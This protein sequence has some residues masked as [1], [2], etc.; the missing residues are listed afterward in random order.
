[1]KFSATGKFRIIFI[2]TV[3]ILAAGLT[4]FGIFGYN[5]AADYKDGYQLNVSV[6]ENFGEA[7]DV[8][9]TATDEYLSA[10]GVKSA[11]YGFQ[12]IDDGEALVYKFATDIGDKIDTAELEASVK[13]ALTDESSVLSGLEVTCEYDSTINYFDS[14][15]I[16]LII[17]GCIS[18]VAIFVYI[19]IMERLAGAVTVAAVTLLSALIFFAALGLTRIPAYP[20]VG[21][22]IVLCAVLSAVFAAGLVSR[23]KEQL[24]NAAGTKVSG[25][26]IADKGTSF[27]MFRIIFIF[28]AL[29]FVSVLFTA[30][31][32]TYIRFMG[33]QLLLADIVA[34]FTAVGYAPFLWSSIKKGSDVKKT[35]KEKP[36]EE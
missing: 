33:L 5:Q 13:Q 25:R 6:S 20:F 7:A 32:P 34:T 11:G 14:Q 16:G 27:G 24:K 8:M 26:E 4:L 2:I 22:M 21:A 3:I 17:A 30:V 15:F 9:K 19:I 36:Q 35:V 23:Y 12:K 1:M 29:A 18:L 28:C 31:G 10:K